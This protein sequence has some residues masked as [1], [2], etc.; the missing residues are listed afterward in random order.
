MRSHHLHL[1]LSKEFVI[2]YLSWCSGH[3]NG[4]STLLDQKGGSSST[5]IKQNIDVEHFFNAGT[6][7]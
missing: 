7:T 6:F 3:L 4:L 5:G 1:G 2:L